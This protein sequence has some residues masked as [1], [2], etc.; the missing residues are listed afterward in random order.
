MRN[1]ACRPAS[2]ARAGWA[3]ASSVASASLKPWKLGKPCSRQKRITEASEEP[4]A[5]ASSVTVCDSTRSGP[6]ST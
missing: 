1:S 3:E 2:S 6:S 5:S 4:E